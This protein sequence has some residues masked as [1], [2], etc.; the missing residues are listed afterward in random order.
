[1]DRNVVLV[2]GATGLIGNPI[3][4]R[5]AEQGRRVRAIVR[6]AARA[7]EYLP[8]SVERVRGDVTEPATIAAAMEGVDLV[9]HAAGMPEQ[10]QPDEA[11]FDRVN[12]QGTVNVLEAALEA[13]VRRVVYT[14]TMDVFAAPRGGTLVESR[15]DEAP[16]PT[17]YERSKQAAEKAAEE[18]RRRGL[19][20]VYVNPSAVYG[21]SPVHV[22]LNAFFIRL[23]HGKVPMLPP[24][25]MSVLYV[26]GCTAA[27]L[28]AAE[29]GR[30]GERYLL[31]DTHV[32]N[33][34][35]AKMI[36]EVGAPSR[37]PPPSAPAWMLGALATVSAP[38]ART[39][40]LAPIIAPGQL[41]FLLWDVRV[42]ASKAQRELGFVP[43]DLRAGVEKT[44]AFLRAD[45]LVP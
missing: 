29:K 16:K 28:T 26:D 21:P 45:K 2:T 25:G 31:A 5:L 24:G 3:A 13:K 19:D 8:R 42:D 34:D 17:A 39:L 27:H 36:L 33:A 18:I 23:L 9:F 7:A 12:R 20:V 44:I 37:K 38:V 32:S 6:N 1:M 14:S 30:S 10:W 11:I 15:L 4:K 22:G 43:Q 41:S 35:L 40:G